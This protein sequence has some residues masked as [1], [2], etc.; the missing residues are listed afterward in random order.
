MVEFIRAIDYAFYIGI[1]EGLIG[2][3][4]FVVT[5]RLYRKI[6]SSSYLI[7]G[8]FLLTFGLWQWMN[9]IN[10]YVL[11]TIYI[12]WAQDPTY[13]DVFPAD[14][15]HWIFMHASLIFLVLHILTLK[16]WSAKHRLEK[17]VA[18]VIA[19]EIISISL[20]RLIYGFFLLVQRDFALY[21]FINV[22]P[23]DRIWFSKLSILMAIFPFD[24]A[25]V[26]I[27]IALYVLLLY[28]YVTLVPVIKDR[29]SRVVKLIWC[30][31]AVIN[32]AN[33]A[34]YYFI[35]YSELEFSVD[36]AYNVGFTILFACFIGVVVILTRFPQAILL[37]GYHMMKAKNLYEF[38]KM[39]KKP[40]TMF[41][42]ILA[43]YLAQLPE[44]LLH[45]I[46]TS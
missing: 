23:T 11:G 31:F 35:A 6:K 33:L 34:V 27:Q 5:V 20:T 21:E 42:S 26:F 36:T 28:N 13:W 39:E 45:T 2:I 43:K 29:T 8:S 10:S 38:T 46:K 3:V 19:Y 25:L 16:D 7:L 40:D 30:L 37:T 22:L 1:L 41:D 44:E 12:A 9:L 4:A 14:I 24:R 32:L 17:G 18:L 15:V